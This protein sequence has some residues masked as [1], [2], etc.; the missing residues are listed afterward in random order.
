MGLQRITHFDAGAVLGDI[1]AL[2]SNDGRITALG[3]QADGGLVRYSFTPPTAAWRTDDL[4]NPA[5]WNVSG[6]I[7]PT[8][9]PVLAEDP[10]PAPGSV[11]Q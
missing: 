3:R 9:D 6:K 5:N 4:V 1:A 8:G 10:A 7:T 2:R 11:L